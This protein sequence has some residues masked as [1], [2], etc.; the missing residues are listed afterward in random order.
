MPLCSTQQYRRILPLAVQA[1]IPTV[2]HRAVPYISNLALS[3]VS[4]ALVL[5]HLYN[6]PASCN[7]K[8]VCSPLRGLPG[9]V[10]GGT[11]PAS[12]KTAARRIRAMWYREE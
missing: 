6:R 4:T 12:S 7:T 3:S 10:T 2:Q 9:S 1:A 11:Q 5:S 8:H